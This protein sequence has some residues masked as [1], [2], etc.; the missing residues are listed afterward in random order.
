MG[1]NRT[2]DDCSTPTRH[3]RVSGQGLTVPESCPPASSAERPA[4]LDQRS[5]GIR[6]AESELHK[7]PTRTGY[8]GCG[9]S[10]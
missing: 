6:P 5:A 2:T 3:S 7:P 8:G 9:A 1:R 10:L 4:E